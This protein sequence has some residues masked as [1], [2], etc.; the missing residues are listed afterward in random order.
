MGVVTALRN[1]DSKSEAEDYER[2]HV[3]EVYQEIADHFSSTRHKV[4]AKKTW[5]DD[6]P[7]KMPMI[8]LLHQS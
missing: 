1:M 5:E 4:S 8:P 3:H 6:N 7:S 2:T